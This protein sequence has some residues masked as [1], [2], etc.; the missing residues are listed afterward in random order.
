MVNIE[1]LD[2]AIEE[3]NDTN[4]N[5]FDDE[6]ILRGYVSSQERHDLEMTLLDM[7]WQRARD[8]GKTVKPIHD[9]RRYEELKKSGEL[10]DVE[11]FYLLTNGKRTKVLDMVPVAHK[12]LDT[13]EG[14]FFAKL[15]L[16]NED[17]P[18]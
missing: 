4:L 2:S 3:T 16:H 8:E 14:N 18:Y 6:R 1:D 5:R 7:Y 11:N 17:H 10:F 9:W 13:P 12:L 15:I